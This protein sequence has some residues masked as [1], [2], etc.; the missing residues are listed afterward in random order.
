VLD[1]PVVADAEEVRGGGL[2]LR[3]GRRDAGV[4][5]R[6]RAGDDRAQSDEI[7]FD[8]HADVLVHLEVKL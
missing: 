2:D 6:V 7:A 1:E 4:V 3:S 5:A 8:Q